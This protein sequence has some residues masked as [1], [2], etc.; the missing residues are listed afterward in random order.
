M[1]AGEDT[2][3]EI[4]ELLEEA[5][6]QWRARQ[7][8]GPVAVA[9]GAIDAP[10]RDGR[11]F[12]ALVG[13]VTGAAAVAAIALAVF[14]V[15]LRPE[16]PSGVGFD[17]QQ[18]SLTPQATSLMQATLPPVT[19]T[20]SNVSATPATDPEVARLRVIEAVNGDPVNFGG[21]YLDEAGDLVIQYVGAN[22]GRAT[23][24]EVLRPGMS[25]RWDKVDR[26][27]AD[28]MRLL[29]Q[30]RERNLD[31]VSAISIDT[32]KNQVKVRVD[33]GQADAISPILEREYGD[34]VAVESAPPFVV[35]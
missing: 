9:R 3:S 27:H 29:R 26:S 11:S 24:E 5:G 25:V 6:A 12:A 31:G 28:L 10:R 2:G 7:I 22:A 33:P 20:P 16:R 1:S 8:F 19:A 32:L 14:A 17:Q 35:Q 4:H 15:G 23:V 30:V 34:A 18:G 21:V 13:G